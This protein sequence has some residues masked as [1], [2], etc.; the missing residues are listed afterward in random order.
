[1][2]LPGVI[3]PRNQWS[4]FTL[5]LTADF[6]SKL[7]VMGLLQTAKNLG[8]Q[9]GCLA[10]VSPTRFHQSLGRCDVTWAQGSHGVGSEGFCGKVLQLGNGK[11]W[12][13][14]E[15]EKFQTH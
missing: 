3:S 7:A 1:M 8:Q 6:G 11:V 4:Y 5:L 14:L 13:C 10:P 9:K 12:S 2:G 15:P